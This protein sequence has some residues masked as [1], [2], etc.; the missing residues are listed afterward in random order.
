METITRISERRS[1]ATDV[2]APRETPTTLAAT[3]TYLL[4]EDG[5]KASLLQGGDGRAVQTVTLQVPTNRL[6]LVS[7]DR[8]GIA[9]LRLRPFFQVDGDQRIVLV[10]AE[11]TFDAPPIVDELYQLAARN[12]ELERAH[13]AAKVSEAAQRHDAQRDVR[14]RAAEA[15]ILDKTARAL[16]HPPPT[17]RVCHLMTPK[18][19][20]RFDVDRESGAAKDVPLEAYRR[21]RTDERA[22]KERRQAERA[23]NLALHEVKKQFIATWIAEHGS[24]EQK[25]RQATGMLPLAEAVE[26]MTD[27]VFSA[28]A[29]YPRYAHD[30]ADRLMSVLPRE[31]REKIG[32]IAPADLHVD[33]EHAQMATAEQ[34]ALVQRI[35]SAVPD[36]TVVLRR[37]R[38]SLRRCELTTLSVAVFG[39]LATQKM[40]PIVTRREFAVP[41][42]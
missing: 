8:E 24:D 5:R 42:A 20:L 19:R 41:D 29:A 27:H 4:S 23:A 7:V 22:T 33:S 34:F 40:G 38:I 2:T 35:R 31:L 10:D 6:H 25:A 17:P 16:P 15:F 26:A 12:H 11:P 37:H 18:G 1:I 30:G 3:A 36:A 32:A 14:Q 21:F 13:H 28:L 9:R 39:I